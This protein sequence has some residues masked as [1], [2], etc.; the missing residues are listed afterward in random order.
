MGQPIWLT[1]ITNIDDNLFFDTMIL[2]F[3]FINH[4]EQ[5]SQTQVLQRCQH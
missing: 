1:L 2:N 3:G 4:F 5:N